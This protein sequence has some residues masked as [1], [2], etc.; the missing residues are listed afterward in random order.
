MAVCD[1]DMTFTFVYIGWEGTV[2]DSRV[3][4]DALKPSN[5]FHIPHEGLNI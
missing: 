4:L 1:F 3:F 2:N 5:N